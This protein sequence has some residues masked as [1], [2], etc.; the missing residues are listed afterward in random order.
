V[1][2]PLDFWVSASTEADRYITFLSFEISDAGAALN[3][4]GNLTALTNGGTIKYS[5][6]AGDI[7]IE[8]ALQSNWDYVRAAR[9]NPAFGNGANSFRANNIS[10][11]SEGFIPVI[12]LREI[13]PPYGIKLDKST[14][15]KLTHTV[16]DNTSPLDSFN[17]IAYGFER[18][19]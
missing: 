9:G 3:E 8:E 10:G 5:T 2:L 7:L 18:F 11:N 4:F 12:D 6:P 17:C 19:E 13:A 1:L 14:K 15:Q 16:N